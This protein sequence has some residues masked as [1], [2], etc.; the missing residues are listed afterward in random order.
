MGV[1]RG[2]DSHEQPY[3]VG[4]V[5]EEAFSL[6]LRV[7]AYMCVISA[8]AVKLR[9]QTLIYILTDTDD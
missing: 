2:I 5:H 9:Q 1:G 6:I 7:E 4:F 8:D 3:A